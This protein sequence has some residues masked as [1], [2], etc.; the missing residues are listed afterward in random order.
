M[1]SDGIDFLGVGG[2]Y[3]QDSPWASF[4]LSVS[5]ILNQ[6]GI[7]TYSKS[8]YFLLNLYEFFFRI[9]FYYYFRSAY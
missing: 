4:D 6:V 1:L 9:S 5:G 7:D 8:F 3:P 2:T